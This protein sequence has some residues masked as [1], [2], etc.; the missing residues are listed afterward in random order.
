MD[1]YLIVLNSIKNIS[2]HYQKNANFYIE[3]YNSIVNSTFL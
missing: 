3:N 1:F 2:H